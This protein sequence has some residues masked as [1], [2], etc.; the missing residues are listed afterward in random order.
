MKKDQ[1]FY[2]INSKAALIKTGS[3]KEL[4]KYVIDGIKKAKNNFFVFNFNWRKQKN[5]LVWKKEIPIFEF[6]AI[7]DEETFE[8]LN[9]E[10]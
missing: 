3:E 5:Q 6:L 2:L 1:Q 7:V 4:T 9:N 8:T 10:N